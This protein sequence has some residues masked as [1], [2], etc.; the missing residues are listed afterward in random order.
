M[1]MSALMAQAQKMQREL[2][3][4]QEAFAEKEFK[5]SKNGMVEIT[6]TGDHNIVRLDIDTDALDA[7][8]KDMLEESIGMCVNEL[9][10]QIDE[11][12]EA[13]KD[14]ITGGA[15]TTGLF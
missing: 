11:E 10:A 13:L 14:K 4:A 1:N 9:I 6:M 5:L 3:K 7:D 12:F 15:N 8:N 2:I